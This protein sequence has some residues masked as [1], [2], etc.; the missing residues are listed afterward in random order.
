MASYTPQSLSEVSQ[1]VSSETAEAYAL[2]C[3]TTLIPD[4]P[5]ATHPLWPYFA[6]FLIFQVWGAKARVEFSK[7]I[8]ANLYNFGGFLPADGK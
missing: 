3:P 5:S 6:F 4:I 8:Q 7:K 2:Q 1:L